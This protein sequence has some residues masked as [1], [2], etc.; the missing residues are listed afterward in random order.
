[1]DMQLTVYNHKGSPCYRCLF[2]TPPPSAACQRCSD[3]GV[4][5][6][7]MPLMLCLTQSSTKAIKRIFFLVFKVELVPF[8]LKVKRIIFKYKQVEHCINRDVVPHLIGLL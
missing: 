1:M 5:G 8:T 6:V 4:L 2:P 3:S 7:G